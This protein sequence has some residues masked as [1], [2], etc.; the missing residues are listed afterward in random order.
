MAVASSQDLCDARV[1]TFLSLALSLPHSSFLHASL[2]P[3]SAPRG[4]QLSSP[5]GLGVR[6]WK[7]HLR[8]FL[9]TC[10]AV[11]IP[12]AI[13]QAIP[14]PLPLRRP[15]VNDHTDVVRQKMVGVGD[16]SSYVV[17]RIESDGGAPRRSLLSLSDVFQNHILS[18]ESLESLEKKALV[19][20]TSVAPS[21]DAFH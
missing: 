4:M 19:V 10:C 13:Y 11:I 18:L 9:H 21:S 2:A 8:S 15:L 6:G 17:A 12:C 16:Y 5:N 1:H 7:R 14:F 20:H 3:W